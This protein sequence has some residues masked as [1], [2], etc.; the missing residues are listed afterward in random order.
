VQPAADG[1]RSPISAGLI[2][3]NDAAAYA[4]DDDVSDKDLRA[5]FQQ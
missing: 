2:H 4:G 1:G 3:L 5:D